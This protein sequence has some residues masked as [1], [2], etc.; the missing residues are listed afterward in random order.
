M[1]LTETD[2]RIWRGADGTPVIDG[3]LFLFQE[4]IRPVLQKSANGV[5]PSRKNQKNSD[6]EAELRAEIE[7]KKG[8]T[9][10][11]TSKEQALINEQLSKEAGIRK[12]VE[13]VRQTITVGL[14]MI[15]S[16]VDIPSN[17]GIDLW[18]YKIICLLL[19]GV[20]QRCGTLV[21]SLPVD[22]YLV[23]L[24]SS[25]FNVE[26]FEIDIGTVRSLQNTAGHCITPQFECR[27]GSRKLDARNGLW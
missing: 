8:I 21:G 19:E 20:L 17:L 25:H 22:T 12:R 3:K 23:R 13:E 4:L 27:R 6:W 26:P 24:L 1:W 15:G 11:L 16:L 14:G 5:V 10:K 2:I 18:Y 7:Q 9:K